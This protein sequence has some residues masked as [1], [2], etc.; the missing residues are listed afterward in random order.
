M[1]KMMVWY[2]MEYT[3]YIFLEER[4]KSIHEK[5]YYKKVTTKRKVN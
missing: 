3:S 5:K 4:R 2:E 1:P